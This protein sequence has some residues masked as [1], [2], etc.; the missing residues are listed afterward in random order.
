MNMRTTLRESQYFLSSI[1]TDKSLNRDML[2]LSQGSWTTAMV[3]FS[4]S[5][6]LLC[7]ASAPFPLSYVRGALLPELDMQI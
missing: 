5:Q 1:Q 4:K 6:Q 7:T 2:H 3:L